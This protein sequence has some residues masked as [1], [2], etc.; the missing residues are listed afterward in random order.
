MRSRRFNRAVDGGVDDKTCVDTLVDS[1][2]VRKAAQ[3][4]LARQRQ[5]GARAGL[6]SPPA[7]VCAAVRTGVSPRSAAAAYSSILGRGKEGEACGSMAPAL[8]RAPPPPPPARAWGGGALALTLSC[9]RSNAWHVGRRWARRAEGRRACAAGLDLEVAVVD[10]QE[11][12]LHHDLLAAV[13]AT[14]ER[15]VRRLR[16][17]SGA[18]FEVHKGLRGQRG[19]EGGGQECSEVR[20]GIRFKGKKGL[21]PAVTEE[22]CCK[23]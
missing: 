23:R 7:Q 5:P 3:T 14:V 10:L 8:G 15:L 22:G 9:T 6:V 2:R 12:V 17:L 20:G 18:K 19:K 16:R 1:L 13:E 11:L 4:A 21:L